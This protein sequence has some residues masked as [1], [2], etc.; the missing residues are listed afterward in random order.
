MRPGYGQAC[1]GPLGSVIATEP[2]EALDMTLWQH[3]GY[4]VSHGGGGRGETP[5]GH[6]DG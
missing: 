2:T 5:G 6:G 1:P 3:S 4:F